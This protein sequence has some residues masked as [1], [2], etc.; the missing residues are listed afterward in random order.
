MIPNDLPLEF[1][2]EVFW[3]REDVQASFPRPVRTKLWRECLRHS[4]RTVFERRKLRLERELKASQV[5]ELIALIV[6][7]TY[8]TQGDSFQLADDEA[9]V[10]IYDLLF[11]H[12]SHIVRRH[13]LTGV[14]EQELEKQM[15]DRS[16]LIE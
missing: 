1:L 7:K 2:A 8:A 15:W 16:V 5:L 13:L 12:D 10:R 11:E 6:S 14:T 4:A 3:Q 9:L